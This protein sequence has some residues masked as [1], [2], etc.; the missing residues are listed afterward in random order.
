MDLKQWIDSPSPIIQNAD[1]VLDT[2]LG[3]FFCNA[4]LSGNGRRQS[5]GALEEEMCSRGGSVGVTQT[6]P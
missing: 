2:S 6:P 5:G 4:S 3:R 1:A